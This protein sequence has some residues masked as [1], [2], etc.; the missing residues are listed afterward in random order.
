MARKPTC[1]CGECRTCKHNA[2][3]RAYY[4]RPGVAERTRDIARLSR[5]RRIEK[6]RAYDRERGYRVYDDAKAMARR[7]VKYA[8]RRGDLTRDPCEVCGGEPTDGHHD[9]YS[10][11]LEV[12]WLCK[13]HHGQAH[14][15]VAA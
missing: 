9:N 8:L 1:E 3:M 2:Y 15:T 5:K 4:R 10:K 7:A 13:T 14:R 6:V 12:R 11:P